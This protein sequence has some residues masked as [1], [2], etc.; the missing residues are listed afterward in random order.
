L[1]WHE[2]GVRG[3]KTTRKGEGRKIR[4]IPGS[5]TGGDLRERG[6]RCSSCGNRKYGRAQE[7]EEG[8]KTKWTN[9]GI[10][11]ATGR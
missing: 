9:F 10:D 5:G 1:T 7:S 2:G 3:W 11:I 4:K 6:V 8:V